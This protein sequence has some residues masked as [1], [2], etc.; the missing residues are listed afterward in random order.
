MEEVKPVTTPTSTT[1][2]KTQV[3]LFEE[4]TL[5][6]KVV[7]SLQYLSLTRLDV[8]FCVNKLYQI[9]QSPSVDHCLLLKEC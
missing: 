2:S 7:G 3:Q 5:Y 9:M 8:A 1:L 4:H 6:K